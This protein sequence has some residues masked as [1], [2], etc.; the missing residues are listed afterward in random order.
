MT[1]EDSTSLTPIDGF[2]GYE[3][4]EQGGRVIQG[5]LIKFT[6]EAK[7][8][9]RDGDEIDPNLELVAAKVARIVQKW[10]DGQSVETHF[11][12]PGEPFP[13]IKAMNAAAPKEEW[14]EDP[15]G[16]PRGPYQKSHVVYLLN[17][18]ATMDRYTYPTSTDGGHIA[19]TELRDKVKWMRRRRETIVYPVV[20]LSDTFFPTRYGGR[21][22][23]H[24]IIKRWVGFGGDG[25]AQALPMPTS[26]TLPPADVKEQPA[27]KN[28][29][30]LR[31]IEPPNLK[32]DLQ[33]EIPSDGSAGKSDRANPDSRAPMKKKAVNQK[34]AAKQPASERARS[35][36]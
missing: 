1:N 13:D 6:N 9:T 4:Q 2:E 33:D 23:P 8:V 10:I 29:A 27:K 3:E 5:T 11:L 30:G 16:N 7:W 19:V 24:F 18:D 32:E 26:T 21:Q 25:N 22:R 34:R 15:G 28:P 31:T 17:D 14:G 12:A 35:R 20:T 36:V